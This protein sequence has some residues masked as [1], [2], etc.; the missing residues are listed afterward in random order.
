MRLII[1]SLRAKRGNLFGIKCHS[2]KGIMELLL[3][4]WG[5]KLGTVPNFPPSK[6]GLAAFFNF[7]DCVLEFF[8]V[9]NGSAFVV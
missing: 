6:R 7:L 5:Y 4:P 2:A 8:W 1:L 9:F 3:S